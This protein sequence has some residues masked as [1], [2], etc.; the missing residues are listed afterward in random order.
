MCCQIDERD[1]FAATFGNLYGRWKVFLDRIVE[2]HLA[3]LRHVS[4]KKRREDLRYR[5][6]LEEC[7][8]IERPLV[9]LFGGTISDDAP[10]VRIDHSDDDADA[11]LLYIDPLD[12]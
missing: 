11:L 9:A 7:V 3:S 1:L 5:T 12:E 2:A 4:R 6:D 10:A 8:S